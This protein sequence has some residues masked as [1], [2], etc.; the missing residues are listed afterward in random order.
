MYHGP[1]KILMPGFYFCKVVGDNGHVNLVFTCKKYLIYFILVAQYL[2]LF[3]FLV[4]LVNVLFFKELH[5]II[6]K[7]P[8]DIVS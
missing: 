7:Y 6:V 5:K 1:Y 8:I 2:H 4:D 3:F